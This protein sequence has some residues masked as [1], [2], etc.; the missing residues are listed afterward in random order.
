MIYSIEI[1]HIIKNI[2]YGKTVYYNIIYFDMCCSVFQLKNLVV[3][4]VSWNE[5]SDISNATF[6]SLQ[7]LKKL[8]IRWCNL[9]SLPKR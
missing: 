8:Y 5:L 9:T 1:K 6:T 3:L 4:N 2:F 7:S